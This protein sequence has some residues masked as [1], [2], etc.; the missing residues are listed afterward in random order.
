M[1]TRNTRKI[2]SADHFYHVYSRGINKQAVFHNDQDRAFFI[3]LFK[4]YLSEKPTFSPY[5][6]P[7]KW[8]GGRLE[9]VCYCLMPNHVHLLVYQ[10]DEK[11]MAEFLHSL[12][13]SYSMYYNQ[14]YK[15]FGPVF[16]SRYLASLIDQDSYLEHITRYIHLNSKDWRTY[17]YSSIGYYTGNKHSS[18]LKP[19]K[20][21]QKFS[22]T[23]DYLTFVRDYED[24][25]QMLD[26]LKLELA[27]D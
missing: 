26:E 13:T 25:K 1:P 23:N 14:K 11:A 10:H 27:H 24:H 21:L 22:S 16:Q 17:P 9:L 5:R 12:M 18:W 15:H 3:S 4:R 6:V 8:F 20:V 19:D 7:Y 2:Y